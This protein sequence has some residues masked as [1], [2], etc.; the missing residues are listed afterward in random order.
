MIK[1]LT[2]DGKQVTF[3]STGAT[4]RLY[5]AQFGSDFLRDVLKM[6][7][8]ITHVRDDAKDGGDIDFANIPME[9]LESIDFEI[10]A[11]MA[12]VLAYTADRDIPDPLNWLDQFEEFPAFELFGELQELM[13]QNFATDKKKTKLAKKAKS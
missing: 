6:A 4:P 10:F 12:W 8:L 2:I 11:N 3:K 9:A 1:T 13:M 7:P 5:K